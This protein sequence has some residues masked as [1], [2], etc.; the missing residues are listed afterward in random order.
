MI[1]ENFKQIYLESPK[2]LPNGLH[3]AT[4][5]ASVVTGPIGRCSFWLEVALQTVRVDF[6]LG[7]PESRRLID[8][9]VKLTGLGRMPKNLTEFHG[10]TIGLRISAGKLIAV[11]SPTPQMPVVEVA[12]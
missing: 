1:R 8:Q 7:T 9:L 2:R 5:V 12:K 4:V 3:D 6:E 10:K 11:E